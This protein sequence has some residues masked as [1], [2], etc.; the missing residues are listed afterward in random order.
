MSLAIA[1]ASGGY[2]VAFIQGV[3][4]TFEKVG[5][6]AEAYAGTSGSVIPAALAAIRQHERHG[7]AYIKGLH[8]Y[9]ALGRGMS[10]VFLESIRFWEPLVRKEL[11]QP[12]RP[13]L[14]IPVSAV[15]T[16]E[17]SALTQGTAVRRLGRQLLLN[18]AQQDNRWVQAHLSLELF[19]TQAVEPALRLTPDN[20]SEVAYASSRMLHAWDIPAWIDE[21]PYIDGSYTCSCPALELAAMGYDE[22]IAISPENGIF[23][24]DLFATQ[25]IPSVW[26]DTLIYTIQPEID[27]KAVGIDYTQATEEGLVTAFQLGEAQGL[28]FL[29][30]WNGHR[31]AA[32]LK[33]TY[34]QKG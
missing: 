28:Q 12:G 34:R 13:R 4:S 22:I 23:Y 30:T 2:R 3:L 21:R 27:L 33:T 15:V 26:G 16:R 1:C 5:L 9:K 18:A 25:A 11:W 20:W 14:L 29:S 19:D 17:A 10:G 7:L 6:Q 31:V 8:E 24:H 32:R